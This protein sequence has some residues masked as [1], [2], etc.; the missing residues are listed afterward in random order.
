MEVLEALCGSSNQYLLDKLAK[1]HQFSLDTDPIFK[2][3]RR[4]MAANYQGY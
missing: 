4:A 3:F 2:V 1:E